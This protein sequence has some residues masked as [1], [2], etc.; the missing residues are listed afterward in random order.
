MDYTFD[1]NNNITQLIN[2][3]RDTSSSWHSET[4]SYS[5][6]GLDRLISA[7]C[8]SWSH[9]YTYDKAGNRSGKDSITYTINSVNEV[10]A[11]SDGTSFTYNDNGN[12]TQKAKGDDTRDYTYDYANRLT[13]VEENDS[14]IGE[15]VYDGD[16]KRLQKT[17]NST[18][19][20]YIYSGI[21]SIYEENSTGS[22]CYVYG[23]TGLITKRTTINQESNIYYYHKDHLGSIRLVTD[24]SRNIIVASTYH[25]FGETEVKEGSEQYLYNGKEKDST[26]LYYY[27][28]RYYD[29]EIGRFI[30]GNLI[31][32]NSMNLQSLNRYSYCLNNPLKYID[33]NGLIEDQFSIDGGG[34]Q[35]EPE[36]TG[37]PSYDGFGEIT[38]PTSMGDVTID[39]DT[40]EGWGDW[41]DKAKENQV[42]EKFREL[43]QGRQKYRE[44]QAKENRQ[45]RDRYWVDFSK[46][47]AIFDNEND[48]T[49]VESRY[50]ALGLGLLLIGA[51]GSASAFLQAGAA[52]AGVA[53]TVGIAVGVVCIA[54]ASIFVVAGVFIGSLIL[55]VAVYGV[56]EGL[57]KWGGF[58]GGLLDF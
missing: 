16:G 18:T 5:Y 11:L 22:A 9:T 48:S 34:T 58:W 44:W 25:P 36:I 14:A 56:D 20:T 46:N 26:G 29:P 6:D 51:A 55:S 24:T 37:D 53:T 15:Y 8:T 54:F 28:A 4:E 41:D 49:S 23:P 47:S 57:A 2:G 30:T 45:I 42:K 21:Y 10:T 31:K 33:P 50:S 13:K 38:I 40:E 52:I 27:G 1:N 3:W 39:L 17:E 19:T 43:E 32:G 12:I 35:E 7:S